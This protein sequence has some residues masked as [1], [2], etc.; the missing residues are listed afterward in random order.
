MSKRS[1]IEAQLKAIRWEVAVL[2]GWRFDDLATR[3]RRAQSLV[4]LAT[5][6][7]ALF[8]PGPTCFLCGGDGKIMEATADYGHPLRSVACPRC[9]TPAPRKHKGAKSL[10]AGSDRA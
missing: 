10:D 3:R 4:S 7:E 9:G 1:A 8:S 2:E 5:R 6:L